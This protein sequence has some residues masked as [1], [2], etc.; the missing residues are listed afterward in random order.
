VQRPKQSRDRNLD[1]CSP[2]I[3]SPSALNDDEVSAGK[4]H[5]AL[6]PD[7]LTCKQCSAVARSGFFGGRAILRENRFPLFPIVL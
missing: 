7:R 3:A 6:K 1:A 5:R 4:N 2:W